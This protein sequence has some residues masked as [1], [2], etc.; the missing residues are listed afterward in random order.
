MSFDQYAQQWDTEKRI[1][2]AK[3]IANEMR[4]NI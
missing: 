1:L 3:I 4:K 2:R